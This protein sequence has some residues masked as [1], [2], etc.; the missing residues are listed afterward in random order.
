MAYASQVFGGILGF[1]LGEA[2]SIFTGI[3]GL[4]ALLL[5]AAGVVFGVFLSDVVTGR[6]PP[7]TK[8]KSH[9]K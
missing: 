5:L 7:K 1:F 6:Y 3:G 8:I 9:K 2:I 4:L